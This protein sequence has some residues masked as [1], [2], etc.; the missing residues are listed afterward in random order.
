L[1]RSL[2]SFKPLKCLVERNGEDEVF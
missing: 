1:H 2:G